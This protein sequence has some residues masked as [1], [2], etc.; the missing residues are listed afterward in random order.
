M[1]VETPV[2]PSVLGCEMLKGSEVGVGIEAFFRGSMERTCCSCYFSATVPSADR[3]GTYSNLN[4]IVSSGQI[5][6]TTLQIGHTATR[7]RRVRLPI[8]FKDDLP[9]SFTTETLSA[10]APIS[11]P[12][13]PLRR[14]LEDAWNT[15]HQASPARLVRT[16]R[17]ALTPILSFST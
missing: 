11:R 17:V 14:L 8:R 4:L 16:G 2:Y 3:N 10:N 6:H 9:L 12:S 15:V 5:L 13:G 7:I 1:A